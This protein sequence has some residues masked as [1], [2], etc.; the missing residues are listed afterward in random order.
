MVLSCIILVIAFT[1]AIFKM[2]YSA[3]EIANLSTANRYLA[4]QLKNQ[5][6]RDRIVSSLK[7]RTMPLKPLKEEDDQIERLAK[8]SYEPAANK[9][10]FNHEIDSL[11]ANE[12]WE[13][14]MNIYKR[15]STAPNCQPQDLAEI[16]D[17]IFSIILSRIVPSDIGALIWFHKSFNLESQHLRHLY[18]FLKRNIAIF[19]AKGLLTLLQMGVSAGEWD[20]SSES[21]KSTLQRGQQQEKLKILSSFE[22]GSRSIYLPAYQNSVQP[23][24][25]S[26]LGPHN[27]FKDFDND[28]TEGSKGRC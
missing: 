26:N 3:D 18:P 27:P 28:L 15:R 22:R 2:V 21:P 4:E 10:N 17:H 11:I 5:Q 25:S 8:K 9:E 1:I 13:I 24:Y 6:E 12:E 20:L 19:D 7:I 23:Q 16:R 14:L